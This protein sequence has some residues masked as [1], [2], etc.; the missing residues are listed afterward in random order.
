MKSG[1]TVEV[2]EKEEEIT[3]IEFAYIGILF[4]SSISFK[5]ASCSHVNYKPC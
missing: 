5:S 4:S 2:E 1:S 3:A